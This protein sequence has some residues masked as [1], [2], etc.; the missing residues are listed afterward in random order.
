MTPCETVT[1]LTRPCCI[2][3]SRR[4]ALQ[5][6]VTI[7]RA[8][9]WWWIRS[10]RWVESEY[11]SMQPHFGYAMLPSTPL[12]LS[13]FIHPA[14]KIQKKTNGEAPFLLVTAYAAND[15]VGETINK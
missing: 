13:T 15:R 8:V 6:G 9:V 12:G 10:R 2:L 5:R 7:V 3:T 14:L 4:G 1:K 11:R